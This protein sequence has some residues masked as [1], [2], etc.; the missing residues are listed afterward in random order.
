MAGGINVPTLSPFSAD[1]ELLGELI[2]DQARRI[3]RLKNVVGIAISN[4]VQKHDVL[5]ANERIEVI[6]RTRAGL[7]PDQLLLSCVGEL[8]DSVIDYVAEC[9]T[10]GANAVIVLP[11]KWGRGFEDR[12]LEERLAALVDLTDRFSLPIIVNLGNGDNRRSATSDEISTLAR[13]SDKVIGF[14]LGAND[15]VLHY[16]QDFLALK[17]VERPLA[18]I[19][20]S[21]GA[22]FHNLNTGADGVLSSLSFIA[23][24]EVAELYQASR[25]GRIYDAKAIHGRMSPLIALLSGHDHHIREM[26]YREAAHHRGLLASPNARGIS[27]PLCPHLKNKLHKTIEDIALK[28]VKW[29]TEASNLSLDTA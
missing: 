25:E 5:T 28:P 9:K 27:D 12:A 23:P 1:G 13:H 6:K 18:C 29:V 20:S 14:D 2:T 24:H 26:I 8:S 22:L 10:A 4:T 7:A 16:D 11:T 21:D 15:S 17:S 19:P 3:A